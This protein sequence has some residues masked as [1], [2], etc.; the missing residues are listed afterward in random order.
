M[1]KSVHLEVRSSAL[2]R[3]TEGGQRERRVGR[4][5]RYPDCLPPN[6]GRWLFGSPGSS[7]VLHLAS[8]H[9]S[10]G[11]RGRRC[12]FN[13]KH[14]ST[15][16]PKTSQ[17]TSWRVP[18]RGSA[19]LKAAPLDEKVSLVPQLVVSPSPSFPIAEETFFFAEEVYFRVA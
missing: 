9:R 13:T 14:Q 16:A 1:S 15:K 10:V 4:A 19:L 12:G 18:C 17:R 3:P 8:H 11:Y 6:P 2:F 7:S 5:S